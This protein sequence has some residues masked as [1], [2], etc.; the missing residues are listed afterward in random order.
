MCCSFLVQVCV[1]PLHQNIF[2]KTTAK[3]GHGQFEYCSS[4]PTESFLW[5]LCFESTQIRRY[6]CFTVSIK[7]YLKIS[8]IKIYHS[9]G[10]VQ[11]F[12]WFL[13]DAFVLSLFVKIADG[14]SNIFHKMLSDLVFCKLVQ[15]QLNDTK[16]F[17]QNIMKEKDSKNNS[18]FLILAYILRHIL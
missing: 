17:I 11:C 9:S 12:S 8:V 4:K 2:C 18:V 5:K 16:I 6:F 14:C 10:H 3:T 15:Q 1:E 13:R 7:F